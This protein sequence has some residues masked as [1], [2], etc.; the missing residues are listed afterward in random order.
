MKRIV[1]LLLF[2]FCSIQICFS[3]D[4]E[5]ELGE[6]V[7]TPYKTAI[8]TRLNPLATD[9]IYVDEA[10]SRGVYSL[11]DAIKDISSVSVATTGSLGGI[12]GVF[13][14]GAGSH[15]TQVILDD[16]RLFD[17]I[18]TSAYFYGYNHMGLNN[19]ERVEVSKGPYASAIYGS[20]AIGG[21][22]NM[23]TRKGKGK[24][25]FSFL[26]E[27][28]SYQT[29]REVLSSDGEIEKLAYSFSVART[30][31]RDF[32]SAKRKN[33][34][35]ETDPYENINS[36]LRLDYSF[37]DDIEAGLIADYTYAKYEYDGD[38][39]LPLYTP[40]DDDDNKAYYYQGVGGINFKQ[41]IGDKF[42]HKI[43]LGY[44]RIYR[45]SWES[46]IT[47]SW[48]KG[49]T[50]QAKWYGDY[51]VSDFDKIIFGFD[52][53]R[54]HGESRLL[55]SGTLYTT[56]K[57][58]TH[59]K[60]YYIE[61]I[62]TPTEDLF[63]AASYRLEDHARFGSKEIY[64]VSGS[65]NIEK[66][67]TKIKFSVGEGFKA[68]SL[69]QSFNGQDGNPNLDP[70]Q[71]ESYDVGLEQNVG[72]LFSFGATYFHTHVKNLIDWIGS[73]YTNSGKARMRG[74][75]SFLEYLIGDESSLKLTHTYMST[76]K[77]SDGTRLLR[78]PNNK[79]TCRFKTL[80]FKKLDLSTGFSYVG[81][82]I[83]FPGTIKLKSYLLAD[84]A[85]NYLFNDNFNV[86]LRFENIL[87]QDYELVSGYQTP[88]FS[89]Y[90]GG[91]VAF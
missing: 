80:L 91:K 36:S 56:P 26:Q 69:Y 31:V 4:K 41:T 24:P 59:T 68:P 12:T 13:I 38:T 58:T 42:Y 8:S 35:Y 18:V 3:S 84:I 55:S 81:N 50:Y 66:T 25:K 83:D 33:G 78:R 72:E 73:G 60:G 77:L 86:F 29:S 89:W 22:I 57:T 70:E 19:L 88:K 16:I 45:K 23:V 63:F 28:G 5:V 75:E 20:D 64:S 7:I 14:R 46:D 44:T 37:T 21:T 11:T 32:Y 1:F 40:T 54:E 43:I 79:A 90:L 65:Y 52:Y 9:V 30:D 82:R 34:N 67:G 51:Q 47:H 85:F 17:P 87:D 71:S 61:N 49:K 10:N 6:I 48:Y 39:G 15:H 27:F 53:L 74:I 62:F 76:K 2:F